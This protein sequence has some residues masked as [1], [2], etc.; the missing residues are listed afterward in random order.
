MIEVFKIVIYK[1]LKYHLN[2]ISIHIKYKYLLDLDIV[3]H[4]INHSILKDLYLLIY[5]VVIIQHN[6][7]NV[8]YVKKEHTIYKLM[9]IYLKL[10]QMNLISQKYVS[11]D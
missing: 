1:G 3:V 7:G 4:I 6:V 8:Q 2:V 5:Q 9:I 10:L 11:I